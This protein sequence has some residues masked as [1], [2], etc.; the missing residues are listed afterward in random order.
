MSE[1]KAR[2]PEKDPNEMVEFCVRCFASSDG[3][4]WGGGPDGPMCSNCCSTG[5][6]FLMP[7]WA[8]KSIYDQASWIGKRYYPNREDFEISAELKA[9][10]VKVKEFPG[11]TVE[12]S[13][14]G[15]DW[16][17]KQDL[18]NGCTREQIV[19]GSVAASKKE[20]L[21]AVVEHMPYVPASRLKE[22]K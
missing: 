10:R 8:V 12:L 18:G 19:P 21:K 11:R 3:G 20:A 4:S 17:V 16:V 7:R 2:K 5:T 13:K 6:S 9:L 1:E 15:T 22:D 14:W